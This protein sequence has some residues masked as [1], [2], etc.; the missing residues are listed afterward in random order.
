MNANLSHHPDASP[1]SN[2]SDTSPVDKTDHNHEDR[3][4]HNPHE[5]VSVTVDGEVKHL[6]KGHYTLPE[7]KATVHI[8][9]DLEVDQVVDGT[10]LPLDDNAVLHIKGGEI[11]ISHVK[12]GGSS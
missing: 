2:D 4:P 8:A 7:F 5:E 3:P 12:Q 10:F 1:E 9:P 6:K 11:F